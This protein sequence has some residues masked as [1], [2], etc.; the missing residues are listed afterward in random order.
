MCD[1]PA[2]APAQPQLWSPCP[3]RQFMSNRPSFS[4]GLVVS[5]SH[6]PKALLPELAAMVRGSWGQRGP[7]RMI[8]T[9]HACCCPPWCPHSTP[10]KSPAFLPLGFCT[11]CPAAF[12]AL[13]FP[14]E[15]PPTPSTTTV[16][17]SPCPR[18]WAAIADKPASWAPCLFCP[19]GYPDTHMTLVRSRCPLPLI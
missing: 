13:T 3:L 17:C 6:H 4:S 10:P 12:P 14:S 5:P 11:C 15:R 18:L 16:L 8:P 9:P 7:R 2:P 19:C 1:P